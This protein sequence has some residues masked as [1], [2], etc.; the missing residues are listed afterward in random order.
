M[1]TNDVPDAQLNRL[2]WQLHLY[3]LVAILLI[4][5]SSLLASVVV[6]KQLYEDTATNNDEYI[7]QSLV[8]LDFEQPV[9]GSGWLPPEDKGTWT[10][11]TA[12]SLRFELKP[13][14]YQVAFWV[15]SLTPEILES[16]AVTVNDSPVEIE[17]HNEGEL[18]R[19]QA[20]IPESVVAQRPDSSIFLFNISHLASPQSLEMSDDPRELGLYFERL[21]VGKSVPVASQNVVIL[22]IF[23]VAALLS[24]GL[25]VTARGILGIH[26]F[27]RNRIFAELLIALILSTVLLWLQNDLIAI[28]QLF[29]FAS[30]GILIGLITIILTPTS[31]SGK[32]NISFISNILNLW[33]NRMLLKIWTQY[34]IKSRYSQAWLG[35]LWIIIQPLATS[36]I[37]AFVFSQIFKSVD[38]NGAP[39]ISFYLVAYV[40]WMLFSIGISNGSVSILGALGL[41]NQVYFPREIVVLVKISEALTDV[42]FT[43]VAVLFVN[44]TLGILPNA[45]YIYLIPVIFIELCLMLGIS[46]FTSY[47]SVFIR[48]VPQFVT[49]VLQFMFYL[50]PILYPLSAIPSSARVIALLNPLAPIVT[51]YRSI[52]LHNT[53][54]DIVSLYY[55][56][57]AAGILVYCGYIFFKQ[58]EKRLTDYV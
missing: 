25:A 7:E 41:V 51:A 26:F 53:P 33:N 38:T 56:G 34:N 16:L 19:V 1:N 55:P 14:R 32:G 44:A 45:N 24:I 13:A 23:F 15:F 4:L 3:D 58:Y 47:L 50:T 43:F 12:A 52:I 30:M 35:I 42:A 21:L 39:F 17:F 8:Q 29:T 11:S 22:M 49:I 18:T 9:D 20:I 57:V 40:G 6:Q 54:P 2:H 31:S 37:L 36:I 48:D 28:S 46:L 10:N 27:T 5:I